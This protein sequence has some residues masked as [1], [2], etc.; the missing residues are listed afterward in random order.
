MQ[1]SEEVEWTII[2][3]EVKLGVVGI[4]VSAAVTMKN[5]IFWD[6]TPCFPV[7]ICLLPDYTSLHP[8]GQSL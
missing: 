8:R 7:Q 1:D 3:T 5:T 4:D 2:G 6:V